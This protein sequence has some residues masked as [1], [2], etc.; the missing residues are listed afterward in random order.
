MG[1]MGLYVYPSCMAK[2]TTDALG[3]YADCIPLEI[4]IEHRL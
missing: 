4:A 3:Q 2:R 1:P